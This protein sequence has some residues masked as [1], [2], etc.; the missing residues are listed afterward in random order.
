MTSLYKNYKYLEPH[1][2]TGGYI[3]RDEKFLFSF[4]EKNN[5]SKRNQEIA[6]RYIDKYFRDP[7]SG[8]SEATVQNNIDILSVI[9]KFVD[10]DLDNLTQDDV[11]TF[12][13]GISKYKKNNGQPIAKASMKHYYV[14]FKQFLKWAAREYHKPEYRDLSENFSTKL[15]TKKKNASDLLT[16]QEID[17]IFAAAIHPRDRAILSVLSESGCRAG[18]L[19]SMQIKH[20]KFTNE[21][22]WV[23]FPQSK[24]TP[25][26]VPL[27]E[28]MIYL[29]AW[30]THHPLKYD[31]EAPL[32]VSL[33]PISATKGGGD[34]AYQPM[35][36]SAVLEL[37]HRLANKAGI[38]KRCYTHLF[39][40]CAATK[41][42]KEWTE[43]RMRNFFGWSTHSAMPSVYSHLGAGDFE[44]AM[45]KL[46]GTAEERKPE[47]KF[48]K[49]P[50]C[51]RELPKRAEYCDVCGTK[52]GKQQV[53]KAD[54]DLASQ[55]RRILLE[56]HP[57]IL[58][59]IVL[60]MTKSQNQ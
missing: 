26:A 39:R 25:R 43:P 14:G 58:Q 40:H 45:R 60:A 47:P 53:Q 49:C 3:L 29:S 46:C 41:M 28:S 15:K 7:G 18:E 6:W 13:I 48:Q 30:L 17:K 23:T 8:L 32:W 34:R 20:V 38:K 59:K 57:E 56:E 37:V 11:D 5:T 4:F 19:V 9:L 42:S 44:E 24:T 10:T 35:P 52:L 31:E 22:V 50:R 27:K 2:I 36:R 1:Y 16:E 54:D 33:N 21:F 51:K 55:M 12:K